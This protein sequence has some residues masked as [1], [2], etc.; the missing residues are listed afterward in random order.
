MSSEPIVRCWFMDGRRE[1]VRCLSF[2]LCLAFATGCSRQPDDGLEKFPVTG[3]V[4]VDG[5]PAEGV[6]VRFFRDGKPGTTNADTPLGVT[7]ADGRFDLSTNGDADGAVAG[8]YRVTFT[9]KPGNSPASKD[10]LGGR[11]TK[12]EKSEVTVTVGPDSNELDP[13]LLESPPAGSETP[14]RP[15]GRSRVNP[16]APAAGERISRA[17]S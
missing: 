1:L 11:Y 9:W 2:L 16:N 5:Q 17:R 7:K 13:F 14:A 12:L 15:R 8:E 10:R 3:Q 4:Q 6:V